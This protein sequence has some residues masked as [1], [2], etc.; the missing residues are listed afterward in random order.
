MC[1]T[2]NPS[3]RSVM[4]RWRGV[5]ANAPLLYGLHCVRVDLNE[6]KI[7]DV[8]QYW[9]PGSALGLGDKWPKARD[10]RMLQRYRDSPLSLGIVVLTCRVDSE[11]LCKF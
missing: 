6:H 4:C 3:V 2:Y 1:D 7:V 5:I 9:H 10:Y 8:W 11:R